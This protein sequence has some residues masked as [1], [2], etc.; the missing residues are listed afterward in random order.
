MKKLDRP[1][2]SHPPVP[3]VTTLVEENG[4]RFAER[5][6]LIQGD[7][8]VSWGQMRENVNRFA[9]ALRT[10]GI[11]KGDRVA[12]LSRNSIAYS[13]AFVGVLTAGACAV[14]LPTM[15]SPEALRLMIADCGA[16][17]L[18]VSDAYKDAV[19]SYVDGFE[20]ILPD[21]K[22][23]FD[24]QSDGFTPYA[25]W[26]RDSSASF[27]GVE[28][29]AEDDF[30]I[31]YSSGTTGVPK[32]ILHSHGVRQ[33]Y[34]NRTGRL[35][36]EDRAINIVSTPLYSNTTITAWLPT[37]AWGGVNV[38][39]AKFDA[40]EFL[41]LVQ[42]HRA[43]HA[44]LV[45][46]QYE[47][48]MQLPDFADFDLSSMRVTLCTGAPL[49]LQV[50]QW[51]RDN[52]PG[53]LIEIYGLTEGGSVTMLS[54]KSHPDK[55]ASVG[56]PP[57]G[58]EIKIIDEQGRSLPTGRVGEVVGRSPNMMLGYVNRDQDTQKMLWRD[59]D[60]KLF[61]RSGDIGRLDEDGFL[62]LMD[63]KRDVIISGGFNVY[64]TDLEEVLARHPTVRDVAVVGVPSDKWGEE[65]AALVVLGAEAH[66]T[67]EQLREWANARLGK[68]QR[69]ARVHFRD[70]L[71]RNEIGKTLKRELRA[72]LLALDE[73]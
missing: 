21:G 29:R 40:R 28:I 31:I 48:I 16:K 12:L 45:P 24:F 15:A 68:A 6:A 41:G 67:E 38:L 18:V 36:F 50:K 2:S 72:S 65:P 64:A 69:I 49:R 52:F 9:N 5:T 73:E 26:L 39:M 56:R 55:L 8:N 19:L 57:R 33:V 35:R 7:R 46:T 60:G 70:Q 23:G 27:P 34:F 11:D 66:I 14:P 30:N 71:P 43:T 61:F 53:E 32:G 3:L 25:Q 44:M 10:L 1:L 22:I 17:V 20:A 58:S 37:L 47:R 54:T 51:M 42:R 63:R 13:E 4:Q 62:Y 59:T